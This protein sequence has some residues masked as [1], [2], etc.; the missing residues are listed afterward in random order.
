M[1]NFCTLFD[2]YY[3]SRGLTMYESLR[4][5]C[6]SFHLYI[7]TFDKKSE[8]ILKSLNLQATTIIALEDFENERLLA[9]KGSRSKAEYCWTCTPST[10]H[11]CIQNFNLDH[12]TYIDADLYFFADPIT[13]VNEL[14]KDSVLLT[15]H[16]YTKSYDQSKTSGIYCVQFMTFRNTTEGVAALTWWLDRCIEWCFDRFEDGKFGDQKYLDDWTTRF[17]GVHV[18]QHPGGGLAPWNI[19]QYAV[20]NRNNDFFVEDKKTK[21]EYPVIFYHFHAVKFL[22]TSVDMGTYRLSEGVKKLYSFYIQKILETNKRLEA[23][24][25]TPIVQAYTTKKSIPVVL[26]KLLRIIIGVFNIRSYKKFLA[27]G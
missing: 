15:E 18:L 10:I 1:L 19:Q 9:I 17:S 11:Y 23:L 7:F 26:H 24:N 6:S 16:R 22:Q 13:L 5:N 8:S 3:L 14:G 2:S 20:L 25:F 27:H 12:C 4:K 21:K